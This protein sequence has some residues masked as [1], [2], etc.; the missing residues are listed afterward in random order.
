MKSFPSEI[1]HKVDSKEIKGIVKILQYIR[2]IHIIFIEGDET[3]N[4]KVESYY[5]T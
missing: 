2:T 5:R 3:S 4:G 1:E